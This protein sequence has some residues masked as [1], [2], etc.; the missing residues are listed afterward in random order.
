MVASDPTVKEEF[1]KKLA[2]DPVFAASARARLNF[3]YERTPYHD[4]RL[5][6]YPVGRIFERVANP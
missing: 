4:D 2:A 1:E 3:F 5:N 6:V